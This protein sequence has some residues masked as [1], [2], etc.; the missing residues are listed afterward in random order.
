MGAPRSGTTELHWQKS[1]LS[2]GSRDG[3]EFA[4][5]RPHRSRI[6]LQSRS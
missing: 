1:D 3:I 2:S 6:D 5:H 4:G